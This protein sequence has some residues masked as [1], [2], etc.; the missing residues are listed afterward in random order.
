MQRLE[1]FID[2]ENSNG[3]R[4]GSGPITTA[5]YWRQTF[6]MDRAGWFETAVPVADPQFQYAQNEYV[7][8]CYVNIPGVGKSEI[9]SGV[10]DDITYQL[11]PN[12]TI[13][14]IRGLD[15]MR[16]LL[17]RSVLFLALGGSGSP[18]TVSH[19]TSVSSIE[20]YAPAGWTFTE[21]S[22]PPFDAVIYRFVGESVLN[23]CIKIAEFCKTHFYLSASKT[24]TFKSTFSAS[25]VTAIHKPPFG[26]T[27][28]SDICFISSYTYHK[29][30]K[31]L[32][33]KMY[34]YGGW[35]NGVFTDEFI[36]AVNDV[37]YGLGGGDPDYWA[38][39][40]YTGYDDDRTNNWIKNN[41]AFTT[42]GARERQVQ[43]P[44]VKVTFFTG[45]YSD[46]IW[47][48]LCRL[49]YNRAVADLAWYGVEAEFYSLELAQ[50]TAILK[51]LQTMR[52]MINKVE[53]NRR[54]FT[55]DSNLL[56]LQSTIEVTA[57]GIRTTKLD[58]TTA[59]RYRRQDPYATVDFKNRY[60]DDMNQ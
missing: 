23:A 25:G 48:D 5:L 55:V 45:G 21:D 38:S 59:E 46:E 22:A 17:D 2:I 10:I 15:E 51:P 60:F 19:A 30:T 8:R 41:S 29:E 58:V 35:Y 34:P 12:G 54:V 43:Y 16:Y 36:P 57:Q 47:R 31:D 33:T 4:Q 52:V 13:A 42:Y 3:T 14:H 24:I 44:Q 18:P 53:N 6:A 28:S 20:A 56:I 37:N 49:I 40:K 9:G 39:P 7:L 50:C 1:Y 26:L 27:S 32:I 11:T